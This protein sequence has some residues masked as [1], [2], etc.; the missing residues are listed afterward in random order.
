MEDTHNVGTP[1]E[2]VNDSQN[3]T[4]VQLG[5]DDP[6][7]HAV[8]GYFVDKVDKG[9]DGNDNGL[10]NTRKSFV[11][12]VNDVNEGQSM[13]QAKSQDT[14]NVADAMKDKNSFADVVS[15]TKPTAKVNF[16][17]LF[18]TETVE[19]SDFVLPIK[20]INAVKHRYENSLIGYFVGKRVAFTLVKS[21]VTNTWGKFG[22]QKIMRDDD[23]FFFFKFAS[24]A[25]VEQVLEQG[26]EI[27]QNTPLILNK[28]TPSLSLC[29]DKVTNV[30]I[31]VKMHGVPVVAYSEDSL[32]LI[33]SKIVKSII[34]DAYTSSMCHNKVKIKVKYEWNPLLCMDCHVFGH[35]P[36]QCPKRV[37]ETVTSTKE[38]VAMSSDGFTTVVNKK[39]KGKKQEATQS[40]HIEG[41]KIHKPKSTFVYH[42][43]HSQPAVN[44]TCKDEPTNMVQLQNHF[45][46]LREQDD[47]LHEVN[48]DDSQVGKHDKEA[49]STSNVKNVESDSEIEE[50]YVELNATKEA[51]T[52]SEQL[53]VCVVLESHVDLVVLSRNCDIVNVLVIAQSDQ[54]MHVKITYKADNKSMYCSSYTLVMPSV[55]DSAWKILKFWMSIALAC[56]TLGTKKTK[57]GNGLLKKLDRIMG[58]IELVDSFPGAYAV[59]QPYRISNHS[60]AV[61][62]KLKRLKKPLRKLLT[63]QGNI[64]DRV[65][66]LRHELDEVQKA[67]DLNPMDTTLHDEEAVY[68]QAFNEAKLDE[69]RFLKQKSKIKWLK[70]GDSNSY[71]FHKSIKNRNQRSQIDA[72]LGS[73]NMVITKAGV[74]DVFVNHYQMFLGNNMVCDELNVEGL[75]TK[76]VSEVS[77]NHMIRDVSNEEI[78][79]AMFDIEDDRAPGLDGYT[80]AIFKKGY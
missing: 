72:I 57:R 8:K 69:E 76:K 22:F 32:S 29:K 30:P 50:M 28:W 39:K 21:Y 31:W 64:H 10:T 46:A 35:T 25:G 63:N 27:I 15:S 5:W 20:T 62:S 45:D 75:F 74:T 7:V 44:I 11:N 48:L 65:N 52:S 47:V 13:D 40:K 49:T 73:D 6:K 42:F 51:S 56:N 61:V 58:N 23:G 17:T 2:V 38:D 41:L 79:R 70:V 55:L 33:G 4:Q 24:I 37:S 36:A 59:F 1:T 19:D 67:L 16:G 9:L 66:C 18:N 14:C 43:K 68:V 77:A 3:P 60:P 80:S 34:L 71:Y 53:S 12:M 26:P 54:A 78:K